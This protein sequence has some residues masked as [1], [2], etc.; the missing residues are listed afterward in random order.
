M[1]AQNTG[2]PGARLADW[3][4][5][6]ENPWFARNTANRV[7]F[8]LLGSGIV[9][10]PDDFRSTNPPANPELLDYLAEEFVRSGYD[11]KQVVRLVLNSRTYQL[12]SRPNRWNEHD[13]PH[14]S[15]YPPLSSREEDISLVP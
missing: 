14:F 5:A 7:W 11:M 4:T 3:T 12:S 2:D 13:E 9:H 6:P 10:K 1:L 8:W 15:H